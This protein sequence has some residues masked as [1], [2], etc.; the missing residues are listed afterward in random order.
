MLSCATVGILFAAS[1]KPNDDDDNSIKPKGSAPVWAPNMTNEMLTIIEELDS[2]YQAPIE[3]VSPQAARNQKTIFDAAGNV[4]LRYSLNA[5]V[6]TVDATDQ[7]INV[8]GTQLNVR[9]YRPHTGAGPFGGIVYY[10]GGGWVTGTSQTY[11]PSARSI[12]EQTGAVVVS[13]DYRR[14]PE[15]KFPT[16]HNDAFA[17]YQW[18]LANTSFLN[19]DA[20]R[21]AVAGEGAGGNL[22]CNVS[23]M[24]RDAGATMPKHQLLIYPIAFTN[25]STPS[26]AQYGSAKPLNMAQVN[27][28][29]NNYLVNTIQRTDARISLVNADVTNL[30]PT[31]IINADIDPL[32]DD[33]LNL[34]GNL[35]AHGVLVT[36]KIYDGVTHDF[37]G[38][39]VIL[40]QA[41]EAEGYAAAALR[42][43]IQ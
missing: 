7:T 42:Q 11:D 37:F 30:P 6:Y 10:H 18:V 4:A 28:F 15:A 33:G 5:P 16:A 31:T 32:R 40:P 9:I 21:V 12:A 26:Y 8:N 38:L 29:L 43:A 1:C 41:R 2:F 27:Y 3:T 35:R 34:E 39:N 13:V 22:A 23:M 36:R 24:A 20:N 19:I 25:M 14:G 17:A